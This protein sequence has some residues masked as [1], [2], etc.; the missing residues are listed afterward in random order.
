MDIQRLLSQ[1]EACTRIEEAVAMMEDYEK[2]DYLEAIEVAPRL[3]L[4]ESDPTRFFKFTNGNAAAAARKLVLYWK[5]RREVFG[6]RAFF[7]LTLTGNGALSTNDIEFFKTGLAV[8]LPND[9]D[10][11]TVVCL[12]PSRRL[13]HSMETRLRCIFYICQVISENEKSQTDGFVLLNAAG[14]KIDMAMTQSRNLV[15]NAFPMKV[16]AFHLIKCMPKWTNNCLTQ[17]LIGGMVRL[18]GQVMQGCQT[19]IHASEDKEEIVQSLESHGISRNGLPRCIGGSWSYE[20]FSDWLTERAQMDQEWHPEQSLSAVVIAPGGAVTNSDDGAFTSYRAEHGDGDDDGDVLNVSSDTSSST[21]DATSLSLTD[22]ATFSPTGSAASLAATVGDGSASGLSI[23]RDEMYQYLR[24]QMGK[25]IEQL[26]QDEKASYIEALEK[27]PAQ[28]WKEES[29]PDAFLRVEDFHVKYAAKRICRYWQ[30]RSET[31]GPKRFRSLYQTGEDALGIRE[32]KVLQSDSIILLPKDAQGCPVLSIDGSCLENRRNWIEARDRCILYMFS[33]LAED[34]MSQQEGAVLVY[35]MDSPPF[36]SVDVAFLE[37]LATSLPLR[38]KAV[39]LLSHEPI[40]FLVESQINFGDKTYVHV[41]S[42]NEELASQLEIFG[43]NKAGLPRFL[44]GEWGL[45]KYIE[46]QEFRTRMEFK[47]SLCIDARDRLKIYDDFPSIKPYS[48][49]RE[50]EKAERNRRLN[51]VHCRRKRDQRR[52]ESAALEEGYTILKGQQ[53]ELLKENRR[54]ED[55]VRT[56][57]AIVEQV[58]EE[59]GN[60][61]SVQAETSS[62]SWSSADFSEILDSISTDV[63][64]WLGSDS[65]S[66]A[67][68]MTNA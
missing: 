20:R 21:G 60:L 48:L 29:N 9:A 64:W 7:P 43:M 55:L 49:L 67:G 65:P 16:K 2:E 6:D 54:L 25:A 47:I 13:D 34:E 66:S 38:F 40:P 56:A 30:L 10:G 61:T 50:N 51:V 17:A 33:L 45:G 46:W 18:Y 24:N 36:H 62:P 57:V 3:V 11:R 1:R 63:K 52:V 53:T 26:P 23:T 8:F 19:Y 5:R 32:I 68:E 42:S 22:G 27:A 4:L 44:N 28:V 15:M 59:Q 14:D 35:K 39:H 12:D 31:F 41:G 37:R 58:E